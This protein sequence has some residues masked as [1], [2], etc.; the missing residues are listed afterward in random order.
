MPEPND[1]LTRQILTS[2]RRMADDTADADD[3][4]QAPAGGQCPVPRLVARH[5]GIALADSAARE[6]PRLRKLLHRHGAVV[7]SGFQINSSQELTRTAMDLCGGLME[8]TERSTPRRQLGANV[9]SATEYPAH[10]RIQLHNENSYAH[11]WPSTLF[12]WCALPAA[13]GGHNLLA[14]TRRVLSNI[15]DATKQLFEQK[16]VLYLRQLGPPLGMPWRYVFQC[17]SREEMDRLCDE[18]GYQITWRSDES[19]SI[20]RIGDA[21]IVHPQTGERVWFNH[22]L[23]FHESSLDPQIRAGLRTLYGE[24]YLTHQT[25]FG[26]ASPIDASILDELRSAYAQCEMKLL[27][28]KDDV[29]VLDNLLMAHGRDAYRGRRDI[30]LVMGRTIG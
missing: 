23:F 3:W 12:F 30:R 27:L 25:F 16:K 1:A 18:K 19:A 29:L 11:E 7:F 5:S 24:S 13:S 2:R 4:V 22:A 15:S 17:D 6:R 10:Q 26:D 9:Y 21:A 8:Y 20:V 14:D 28:L